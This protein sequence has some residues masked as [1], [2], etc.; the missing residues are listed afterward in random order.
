MSKT[1]SRLLT[2]K[3]VLY[4]R[5]LW[6]PRTYPLWSE[7]KLLHSLLATL[8]A[9]SDK[10]DLELDGLDNLLEDIKDCTKSYYIDIE[11][12]EWGI[13][14]RV[15]LELQIQEIYM[16]I[17]CLA[18]THDLLDISYLEGVKA[19]FSHLDKGILTDEI[20]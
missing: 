16:A 13:A 10:E 9:F 17:E 1:G 18:L 15:K 7:I 14:D 4:N 3:L 6:D 20:T 12:K 2:W 11:F 5:N 8:K 19:D